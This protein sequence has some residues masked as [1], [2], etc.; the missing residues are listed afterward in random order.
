MVKMDTATDFSSIEVS[1]RGDR[2]TGVELELLKVTWID[3]QETY[4]PTQD[5]IVSPPAFRIQ[6]GKG[7]MVRFR[8]TAAR[9]PVEGFYRLFVRQ[10]LE[11]T[12]NGQINMVFNLG[13]PIFIAPLISTPAIAIAKA[14]QP[15][16][17]E[18]R[19]TGNVT[20]TLLQLEGAAC[21]TGPRKLVARL[22]PEQKLVVKSDALNCFSSVR[23]D[24]GPIELA[25]P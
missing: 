2:P 22:S 23:T 7:R 25:R 15:D 5:F 19:N 1:N 21:P 16:E 6:P 24:R 18:L 11:E 20:L 14:A 9:H 17:L 10:L 3:G 13:V 12:G 4:T 8:Y